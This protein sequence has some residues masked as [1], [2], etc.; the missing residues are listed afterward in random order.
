LQSFNLNNLKKYF[1]METISTSINFQEKLNNVVP[2][3]DYE[4]L[5][6]SL[7]EKT[8]EDKI[9]LTLLMASLNK[10]KTL[11]QEQLD[12][13]LYK[14]LQWPTDLLGYNKYL[15]ELSKWRP[16]E[17]N[18]AVWEIPHENGHQEVDDRL[19]HFY[20]LIHQKVGTGS[21]TIVQDIPWFSEWLID[22]AKC[23]GNFLN[24]TDSFNEEKLNSFIENAPKYRV[25]DSLINGKANNP[26]GWL[27]FNQFFARELNPGLR[28]I[29]NPFDN[30][31]V[32][33]PADCNY[34]AQYKITG[35]SSIPEIIIKSTHKFSNIA[36]L[37]E[38]SNYKN[39]FAKGTF[40]HYYLSPFSYHRFHIPVAGTVKECYPIHGLVY[41]DVNIVDKQF[42]SPDN[43][44]DGYQF[45]Q[46]R[47][48]MIVDTTNS[49]YGNIGIVAVIP[50]GMSQ[51]SSVNMIATVGSDLLKG[52][53]FG[54]F[55]FGG[56]DI[57][58]LFQEGVNPQIDINNLYR[59]YGVK[60]ADCTLLK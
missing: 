9:F 20:W 59:H 7:I 4:Q 16:E 36:N 55:L 52:D 60:M 34:R 2:L 31:I 11:A 51:V 46:A 39:D 22:Y 40:V 18:H 13:V 27:T 21:T 38:G 37:L 53:E 19:N 3:L 29:S 10:A 41:C 58:V 8:K 26:S 44:E 25:E 30:K 28:P 5:I 23:W 57:I 14:N 15:K 17:S 43:A 6:G 49:P 48:V 24:T 12:P 35:D 50:I 1:I 56:S 42:D 32:T 45:A 47:G 33:T 54:Y